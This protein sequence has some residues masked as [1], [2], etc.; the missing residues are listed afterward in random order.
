MTLVNL[1]TE[2]ANEK[3]WKISSLRMGHCEKEQK[4]RAVTGNAVT[5]HAFLWCNAIICNFRLPPKN[6]EA[7]L[8]L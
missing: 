8:A 6:I 3:D 7:L 5:N 2:L 4:G 1:F